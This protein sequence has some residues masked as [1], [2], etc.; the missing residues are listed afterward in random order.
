[1]MKKIAYIERQFW[2][3]VSIKN[4]FRQVARNLSPSAFETS[5]QQV[6][7]GNNLQ[8]ILRNLLS[9][10]KP[11]A[12]LY[13]VTGQIHYMTFLLPADKTVLTIHDLRFLHEKKGI[14]RF[15]MK[16]LFLGLP[17]SKVKYL[18][19]ISAATRDEIVAATGCDESKI[20]VIENPVSDAFNFKSERRFDRNCPVILQIGTT[21]NKNLA[22][23]LEAIADLNVRLVV[24]G[25]VES[26]ADDLL[27]KSGVNFELKMNLDDEQMVAEYEAA[28]IVAFCSTYEGFGLPIIEGQAM[29]KPVITSDRSPMRDVAGRGALLVDPDDPKAIRDGLSKMIENDEL[30]GELV[31]AGFENVQRFRPE[32]IAREYEDYYLSIL[33]PPG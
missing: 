12:D 26:D 5:F 14:R 27:R 16:K 20:R 7:F 33:N 8:G 10:R 3:G 19:A 15:A 13:H 31:R 9:F 18:T 30:R 22:N 6:P 4:V 21:A 11:A 17:V 1:M 32:R 24:I 28:D 25:Q 29:G 2:E 23:L